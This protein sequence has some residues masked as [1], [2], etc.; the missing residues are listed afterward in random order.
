MSQE[1][2]NKT[3]VNNVDSLLVQNN[4]IPHEVSVDPDNPDVVL[5]VWVKELSFLQ[6]QRAIKEV[7]NIT[8]DGEV[9]IDLANYWRYML[10]ECV[11]RTEPQMSKAQLLALKPAV[12]SAITTLLPQPQDLVTGP[13]AD[14]SDA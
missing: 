1:E 14:G 7:V 5:R 8:A 2:Q 3:L 10:T 13:L 11:D 4:A 12:A 9:S 6:I